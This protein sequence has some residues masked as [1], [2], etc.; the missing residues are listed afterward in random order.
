[1]RPSFL[2]QL[3]M[4]ENRLY[5]RGMGPKTQRWTELSDNT[6][7]LENEELILR[8]TYLNSQMAPLVD[9]S[10]VNIEG[11]TFQ[12]KWVDESHQQP[13]ASEGPDEEDLINLINPPKQMNHKL[14]KQVRSAIKGSKQISLNGVNN[15]PKSKFL[16]KT[17][18][19]QTQGEKPPLSMYQNQL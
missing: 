4:Y 10:L 12:L 17:S 2:S 18:V 15:N 9:L 8:N 5:Q 11:K 14:N 7:H 16:A 1:M 19:L 3:S 13:L 6:F